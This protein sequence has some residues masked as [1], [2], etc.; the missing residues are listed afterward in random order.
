MDRYATLFRDLTRTCPSM[1]V[2]VD[3][4]MSRHTTFRIGGPV[5]VMA[6]PRTEEEA[7]KAVQVALRHEV[8]PA[9]IEEFRRRTMTAC[10][11]IGKISYLSVLPP[12]GSIYLFVNIKRTGLT[13]KEFASQLLDRYHILVIP[14]NVFGESGEG[15]VRLALTLGEDKIRQAFDRLPRDQ[16]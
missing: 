6:L 4:P 5:R 12:Q 10:E 15:Y 3:E 2:R 16:F 7:V 8:Q 1:E 14:G 9:I 13:S 11:E